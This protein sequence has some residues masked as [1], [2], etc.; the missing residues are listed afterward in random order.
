MAWIQ[1]TAKISFSIA[2]YNVIVRSKLVENGKYNMQNNG[3]VTATASAIL[4]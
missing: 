4:R 1:M 3:P 2:I